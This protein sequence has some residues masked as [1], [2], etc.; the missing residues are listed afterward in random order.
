MVV[1]VMMMEEEEVVVVA[2]AVV[3]VVVEVVVVV[4]A[5]TAAEAAAFSLAS[6]VAVRQGRSLWR[7]HSSTTLSRSAFQASTN[8]SAL[9]SPS[10]SPSPS[11]R[12]PVD[13]DGPRVL[14]R[15]AEGGQDIRLP[16]VEVVRPARWVDA[17]GEE[18][19]SA[20][21]DKAEEEALP[22]LGMPGTPL[23]LRLRV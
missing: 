20:G 6:R 18:P 22:V 2:A 17:V 10:P 1:V 23:D 4:V 19:R 14:E 3:V 9:A 7:R 13:D 5:L 15:L 21:F 11:P 8:P 12:P 16:R